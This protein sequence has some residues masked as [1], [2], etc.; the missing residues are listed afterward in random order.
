MLDIKQFLPDA[1]FIHLIR[2]GQDSAL[3]YRGMWFGPGHNLVRHAK[4]WVAQITA[5]RIQAI[6][7]GNAYTEVRFEQLTTEPEKTLSDICHFIELPYTDTMLDFH[8]TAL[9]RLSQI[10]NRYNSDG[11]L[12]VQS[13]DLLDIFAVTSMPPDTRRIGRWKVHM[14]KNEQQQYEYYADRQL[15]ALGYETRY[16]EL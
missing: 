13:S 16:P 14:R 10:K 8:K 4:T 3:S 5:A 1:R 11:T 12:A 9:C 6:I 2:D 15:H 7:L